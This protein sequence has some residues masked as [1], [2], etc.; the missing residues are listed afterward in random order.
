MSV[1]RNWEIAEGGKGIRVGK[2]EGE[3][4]GIKDKAEQVHN[5]VAGNELRAS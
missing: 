4:G 5:S 3:D 1:H 2:G